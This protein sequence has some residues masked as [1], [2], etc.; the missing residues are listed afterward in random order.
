MQLVIFFH[1]K[2]IIQH[3]AR[4]NYRGSAASYNTWQT[5][6]KDRILTQVFD[7]QSDEIKCLNVVYRIN[8]TWKFHQVQQIDLPI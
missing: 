5:N 3:W 1:S 2:Q 7:A 8:L 6:N 4:K